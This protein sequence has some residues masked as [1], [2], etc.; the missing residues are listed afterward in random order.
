MYVYKLCIPDGTICTIC[1][2]IHTYLGVVTEMFIYIFIY[3]YVL[4][5]I[6]RKICLWFDAPYVND[7][8]CQNFLSTKSFLIY[9]SC[10]YWILYVIIMAT[11]PDFEFHLGLVQHDICI[12]VIKSQFHRQSW[13]Y[14]CSTHH[15]LFL[16]PFMVG[17]AV[18]GSM[19]KC[20][21]YAVLLFCVIS[22][23]VRVKTMN[24]LSVCQNQCI[25]S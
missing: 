23:C 11:L 3:V 16:H 22:L 15:C 24:I 12:N 13:H 9:V 17:T 10:T 7:T 6:Q 21:C 2:Y 8:L 5:H 20:L 19:C 18:D 14:L 25:V 4:M 1:G